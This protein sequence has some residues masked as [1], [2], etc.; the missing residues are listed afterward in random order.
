MGA[1]PRIVSLVP[2]TT[3]S[4]CALGRGDRLVGCTRYCEEPA[5]ELA[6]VTRVGGTKNPAREVIAGLRPDLIL[7]NAEENRPDDIAWLAER[8]RVLVQTP[9]TVVEATQHLRELAQV[10]G[11]EDAVQPFLLRIEARI[12]AAQ[13]AAVEATPLGVFYPIWRKP[14]MTVN[15]DTFVHD[16]L[17]VVGLRNIAAAAP[18]RYPE[19]DLEQVRSHGPD[20]VLLPSEPWVFVPND[21]EELV[22][23]DAFGT[24]VVELCDGRDFCWHGVRIADGLGRALD[25]AARLRRAVRRRGE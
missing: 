2:S 4:V 7:A 5:A 15:A 9:R 21:R 10:L 16:V 13:V 12:A 8:A 25:L 22:R 1:P 20:A 19:I 14:W 17:R 6:A 11:A 18:A 24:S 23:D 3:E